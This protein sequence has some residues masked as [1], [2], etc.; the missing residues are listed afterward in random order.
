[1]SQSR[2]GLT[3]Q[4]AALA[5]QRP[6]AQFHDK[7]VVNVPS[8]AAAITPTLYANAYTA[9]ADVAVFAAVVTVRRIGPANVTR[10]S[11]RRHHPRRGV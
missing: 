4:A 7:Y 9:E 8:L 3:V 6:V 5:G 11:A 1:M 10:G 2:H